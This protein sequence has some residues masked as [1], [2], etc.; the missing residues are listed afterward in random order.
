MNTTK[1]STS[2]MFACTPTGICLPTYVVYKGQRMQDTWITGGPSDTIYNCSKSGWFD[3]DTFI[4]WFKKVIIP[5]S[6]RLPANEPKVVLGDNLASHLSFEVV[7]LCEEHNI[8]MTFLPP[9]ATHL[10]QPL[11]VGCYA[12]LKRAWRGVLETWEMGEGKHLASMPKWA[13]PSLLLSL[14]AELDDKWPQLCASAFRTCGIHPFSPEAVLRKMNHE[15]NQPE[16]VSQEL[17]SYLKETRENSV[18]PRAPRR[19]RIDVPAGASVSLADLESSSSS[20]DTSR[21]QVSSEH[22]TSRKI[23]RIVSTSSVAEESDEEVLD[24]LLHNLDD[25]EE[26]QDTA[27]TTNTS[28]QSL[29]FDV[30]S[31]V[32]V[33]FEQKGKTDVH[34]VGK[35]TGKIDNSCWDIEYYRKT[36]GDDYR[37]G[38]SLP[39][40]RDKAVIYVNDVVAVLAVKD[41]SKQKIFFEKDQFNDYLVR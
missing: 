19:K 31:Y 40:N 16:N 32:L 7:E 12:P 36:E 30:G 24:F 10:L 33:R 14:M 29:Q 22:P 39:S 17:L 38:F 18:K 34:Y 28:T 35:I 20:T 4:D 11:D 23:R 5:F 3:A 37:Y 27:G 41:C 8:R 15:E 26:P 25:N 1:S 9:N 6:R 13:F 21:P 2:I